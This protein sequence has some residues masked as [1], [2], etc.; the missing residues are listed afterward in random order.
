MARMKSMFRSHE[1]MQAQ[2]TV[3][4]THASCPLRDT[5]QLYQEHSMWLSLSSQVSRLH[6]LWVQQA[7]IIF[8]PSAN[9][10]IH[11]NFQFLIPSAIV[12]D[13]SNFRQMSTYNFTCVGLPSNGNL[14]WTMDGIGK[15]TLLNI[16][17]PATS[18]PYFIE[19]ISSREVRFVLFSS[20][21]SSLGRQRLKCMSQE[22]GINASM[23]LAQ[24][25]Q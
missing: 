2:H 7:T 22:S 13:Y 19:T 23:L 14:V 17:D 4:C 25:R 15:S 8:S 20:R 18:G 11:A 10:A 12:N 5:L 9:V 3:E 24:G 6:V 16:T 1:W 21:A